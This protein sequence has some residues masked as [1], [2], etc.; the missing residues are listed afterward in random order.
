MKDELGGKIV[1]E[2]AA[3]RPKIYAYL[4]DDC[5]NATIKNATGTKKCVIKRIPKFNDY[6]NC[7]S[8]NET[9][10]KSQQI[11]KIKAHNVYTEEIKK[12]PLRCNN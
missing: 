7:L 10:L 5:C 9:I 6:K 4:M 12:I 8:N 2:S 1:A 3:L 11:F